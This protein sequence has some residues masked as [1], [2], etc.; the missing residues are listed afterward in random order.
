MS[1]KKPYTRS[2]PSCTLKRA[3]N[4][5]EFF[6]LKLSTKVNFCLIF[7]VRRDHQNDSIQSIKYYEK[8]MNR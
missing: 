1:G 7:G 8:N 4:R 3:P 6:Q 5:L 2:L